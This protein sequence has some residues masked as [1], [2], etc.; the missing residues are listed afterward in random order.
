[1]FLQEHFCRNYGVRSCKC[2]EV[3]LQEH[4]GKLSEHLL[5]FATISCV[6]PLFPYMRADSSLR[7]RMSPILWK[8]HP[9]YYL[10]DSTI[11]RRMAIAK[12]LDCESGMG[13]GGGQVREGWDERAWLSCARPTRSAK[14]PPFVTK[15]AAVGRIDSNRSTARRVTTSKFIPAR[16]S[17]RVFCILM[18]V[19]VRARVT[20]RR[21]AAFFWLDSIRVKEISGA[22]SF[23]GMPGKP[24]PEPR[25]ATLT[26]S[27]MAARGASAAR[28]VES[29]T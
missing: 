24:A 11:C 21:N 4:C 15:A 18:F 26:A 13:M 14:R 9:T 16:D 22:Q 7:A 17:A 27:L 10:V 2:D 12:T 25:S 19:N 6:L 20:S 1:M 8:V 28:N 23:I 29:C 3:F 5:Y